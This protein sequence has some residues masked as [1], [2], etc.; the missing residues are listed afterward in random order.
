[1][2]GRFKKSKSTIVW[3]NNSSVVPD[4]RNSDLSLI[5]DATS[6][7]A[8]NAS[9]NKI[10]TL[11]CLQQIYNA[12]EFVPSANINNSIGITGFLVAFNVPAPLQVR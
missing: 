9:C 10:I 4:S 6:G 11:S 8:V 1:M 2:F 3:S 7:V 12:V 5:V